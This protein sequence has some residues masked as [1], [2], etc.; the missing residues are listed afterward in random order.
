MKKLLALLLLSPLVVSEELKLTCEAG[1]QIWY[2]SLMLD[3][4]EAYYFQHNIPNTDSPKKLT[5]ELI[6]KS[7]F[8]EKNLFKNYWIYPSYFLLKDVSRIRKGGTTN[9]VINRLTLRGRI[10]QSNGDLP[11]AAECFE[12]FKSYEKKI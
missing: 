11:L 7:I 6:N 1:P 12:G 5:P 10:S 4:T 3:G 9:I 8:G 2:I